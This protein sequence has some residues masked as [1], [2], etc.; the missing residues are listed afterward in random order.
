[1]AAGKSTRMKSSRPKA[2]HEICGRA[3]GRHIVDACFKAGIG[4]VVVVVGHEPEQVKQAIGEDVIYVTQHQQLGTGHAVMSAKD[5]FH[6]FAGSLAVLPADT[7]LIRAESIRVMME[8]LETTGSAATLLTAVLD[9][10][11]S[12]GRIVRGGDGMVQEIREAKDANEDILAIREINTSI[13]AFN[14]SLLFPALDNITSENQQKEYYLTDVI[15]VFVKEGRQVTASVAEDWRECVGINTRVELAEATAL[16]RQRI[17]SGHML[18]GVTILDPASVYID[19]GVTIG[20]D[21]VIGPGTLLEGNT[22]IGANCEIGPYTRIKDCEISDCVKIEFSHLDQARV[23]SG[24]KMGPYARLRP[25][26]VIEAGCKLGNFVEVKN[27]TLHE[28]VALGH[29]SYIGDAEVGSGTNIGAGAITCNY[30]GKTKHRTTIGE[31][32]FIGSDTILNAPVTV[33]D[34]AFTA[35]G[36]V[37]SKDVPPDALAISRPQLV[38]REGWAKRRREAAKE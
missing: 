22:R 8:S 17:L 14:S 6:G 37:V 9:E 16:M 25:G 2:A 38:I 29:L 20:Q 34:G 13:Y 23:L 35:S 18:A 4:R 7:P 21:T 19:S 30:D 31:G 32:A 11:G 28:K 33:G 12:Y 5:A 1:M 36:S 27:S 15:G 26:S 3:I 10:A 24:V